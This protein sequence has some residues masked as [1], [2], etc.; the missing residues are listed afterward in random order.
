MK[1]IHLNNIA[2]VSETISEAQ[3]KYLGYDS[4]II[5][6][7]PYQKSFSI[8]QKLFTLIPRL[9]LILTARYFIGK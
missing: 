7:I 5:N 3:K 4:Q 2:S 1:I 6:I 9:K 8:K